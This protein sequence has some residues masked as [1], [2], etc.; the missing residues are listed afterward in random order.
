MQMATLQ[1]KRLPDDVYAAL[2][3]RAAEQ[4]VS[5]SDLVTRILRRDLAYP[6]L[7]QWLD[8]LPSRAGPGREVDIEALID[9]IR[10]E[11]R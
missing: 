3:R 7:P 2:K 9:N 6:S 11:K 5:L 1:V 8:A 10:D 4:G